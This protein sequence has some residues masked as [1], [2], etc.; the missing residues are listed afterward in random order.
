M[1]RAPVASA[2]LAAVALAGCLETAGP[3]APAPLAPSAADQSSPAYAA[4]RRAIASTTGRP[5]ADVAIFDYLDSEAGT[6]VQASVAGAE[7]PWRCLSS[8]DGVVAEVI[9][10]GSEGRL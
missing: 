4:C 7:A 6:Q 8:N 2:L 1:P 9:Y 10:T 5:V 3:E